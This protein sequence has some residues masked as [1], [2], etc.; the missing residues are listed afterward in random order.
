MQ[1]ILL[2]IAALLIVGQVS[3]Q[4]ARVRKYTTPLLGTV[5]LKDVEDKYNVQ[6]YNL[7]MPEPDAE[8]EHEKLQQI[9]EQSRKLFPYKRAVSQKKTTAVTPP[10]VSVSFLADSLPGVPPDNYM[11]ISKAN[12]AISVMNSSLAV[13][14]GTTGQMSLR[15]SLKLLS[16]AG[17]AGLNGI[18]DYRY[19]PKVIYDPVAD[20][21]I[22]V[23][24]NATNDLNYIVLGFSKTNDPEGAWQFYK[25]YGNYGGDT[26]WFDYPCIAIT[27]DEF[28]LTGNKIKFNTSWQAGFSES[29]IYQVKKQD[30]YDAAPN[31]TYQIW[32]SINYGGVF[33]RNLFPVKNGSAITGP[34]QYFLSNRNF[35]VQNDSVFLI[36]VP[37]VIGSG[38][39]NIGFTILKSPVSYGV[40]PVGRQP[41]TSVTLAT[42]DGRV[43]GAYAETDEIQ[44]VST[45]V[46]TSTGAS[47]IFHGK[48][49]NYKTSPTISYAAIYGIDTIDMGYPNISFAGNP[50][51]L[52]QSLISFNYTGPNTYPGLGAILFDGTQYS[53]MVSVKAGDSSIKVLTSKEQ[54]WGDYTGS[55]IDWNQPGAVW[56]LGIYGRRDKKY[57]NWMAK[58]NSPLLKV[59]DN[60][61]ANSDVKLYP[62][63][64][65]K[66]I[67][68]EFEVQEPERLAFFIYD[69][70]G[71]VVDKLTEQ[72]CEEGKN[73]IQFDTYSLSSGT[74]YLKVMNTHG[75]IITTKSFVKQ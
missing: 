71:R 33:I 7:E 22:C 65:A 28:F 57:G 48:I 9:K 66:Y 8:P 1:R 32:D 37:D 49:S 47:A 2:S 73:L 6:V 52:K 56:V 17:G 55:Q 21:F 15:K 41:D 58:L 35:D 39:N 29:V 74:Y 18:N 38:N 67:R 20:R 72:Q 36:K 46:N 13:L 62:N 25:F 68:L 75:G 24:L 30:G 26:T 23:M 31:L 45:T 69:V 14:D 42:N 27:K 12:K 59:Q 34:E 11:A 44:F 40:P 4:H 10:V 53:E 63:P 3:A 60:K 64:T 16:N 19:D 61:A 5:V 51:G 50:W 70:T 54:R 43:L